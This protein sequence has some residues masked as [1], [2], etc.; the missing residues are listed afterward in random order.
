VAEIIFKTEGVTKAYDTSKKK[1][2]SLDGLDHVGL[3]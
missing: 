3:G 1:V 2:F